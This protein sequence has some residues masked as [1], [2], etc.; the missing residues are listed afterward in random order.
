M[1]MWYMFDGASSFNQNIV[2]WD[3]SA[4]QG[5][6]RM[7]EGAKLFDQDIGLWNTLAV[8]KNNFIL[9]G[10]LANS[11][12]ARRYGLNTMIIRVTRVPVSLLTI[13]AVAELYA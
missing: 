12:S 8:D 10:S 3:A 1:N 4:I 5:M 9:F 13:S 2:L 11:L 7:F 6:T